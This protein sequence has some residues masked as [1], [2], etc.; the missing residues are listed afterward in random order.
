MLRHL[1]RA[2]DTIIEDL[3]RAIPQAQL[4]IFLTDPCPSWT[5]KSGFSSTAP[6]SPPPDD[7]GSASP[8]HILL[9]LSAGEY[10]G[11]KIKLPA[12]AMSSPRSI[13]VIG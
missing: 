9:T 13:I 6:V 11:T 1:L 10:T 3:L 7:S 4:L 12:L 5:D 2:A 8:H